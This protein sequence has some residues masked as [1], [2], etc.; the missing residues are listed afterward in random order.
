[1]TTKFIVKMSCEDSLREFNTKKQK[2]LIVKLHKKNCE[3]CQTALV[4]K[5]ERKCEFNSMNMEENKIRKDII[6]DL[7]TDA[8]V[9]TPNIKD[10]F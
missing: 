6:T 1:M 5:G 8:Y 9:L 7:F 4:C 2:D 3:K 10:K